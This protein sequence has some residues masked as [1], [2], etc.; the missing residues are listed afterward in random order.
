MDFVDIVKTQLVLQCETSWEIR[1]EGHTLPKELKA[2]V[3][4]A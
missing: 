1:P 3:E 2:Q 4:G